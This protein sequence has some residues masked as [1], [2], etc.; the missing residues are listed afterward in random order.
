MVEID[1]ENIPL[2]IVQETKVRKKRKRWYQIQIINSNVR[3]R[4]YEENDDTN[5]NFKCPI[6]TLIMEDGLRLNNP[7]WV[8]NLSSLNIP[9]YD[10]TGAFVDTA[11]VIL[12]NPNMIET[13]ISIMKAEIYD[14]F[15]NQ[16]KKLK[17]E[18]NKY[19]K[20]KI[21]SEQLESYKKYYGDHQ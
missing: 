18:R 11:S 15:N 2:N 5:L 8:L 17:D 20:L 1:P 16:I 7:T 3:V 14:N 4:V 13:F 19:R 21:D 9:K 6:V 12:E 10:M